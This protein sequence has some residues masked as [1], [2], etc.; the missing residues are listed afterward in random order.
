MEFAHRCG[1]PAGGAESRELRERERELRQLTTT[2]LNA[3]TCQFW[4]HNVVCAVRVCV[5]VCVT[6]VSAV[7][8]INLAEISKQNQQSNSKPQTKGLKR[9]EV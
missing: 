5:C 6:E 2:S 7:D 3:A 9:T 4:S 8:A 1:Q